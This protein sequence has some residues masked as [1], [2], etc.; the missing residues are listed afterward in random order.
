MDTQEITTTLD[1]RQRLF[2]A[3]YCDTSS[4]TFG[5]C[6]QSAKK[7]G[8]SD[9]TARN[10]TSNKPQWY[11]EMLGQ[12]RGMEPEHLVVKLSQIINNPRE[13]TQNKLRAIDMLM[14]HN[15]MYEDTHRIHATLNIQ[16][17]LA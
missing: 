1:P 13:K 11:L 4:K 5:N 3:L 17:V 7:A 10:L 2:I 6:Y 15:R 16:D 8:F 12:V 9:L 14:R